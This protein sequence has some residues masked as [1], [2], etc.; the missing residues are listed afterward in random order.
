MNNINKIKN[1]K[2]LVVGF[3]RSGYASAKI[4]KK[5]GANVTLTAI[6]DLNGNSQAEE[7]I[8]L[9]V[10]I[11]SGS[12]PISLL[13]NIDFIVKNPGIKYSGF[14]KEALD[15]NIPV[16]TEIEFTSTL[17]NRDIVAITGTNGKTTTTQ[18][19]YDILK[20]DNKKV[21]LA[22]NIGY[23]SIEVAYNSK[24]GAILVT[25]VSS[26]QLEGTD[27]FKPSIAIITNMT[28]S[29]LD[30][31]DNIENYHNAK[32]KIFK[33]QTKGDYLILNSKD[34][35]KFDIDKINSNILFYSLEKNLNF[36]IY[37]DNNNV[38][39]KGIELFNVDKLLLPGSHNIENA[40]N[41]AVASYLKG[42]SLESIRKIL[43]T[44]TGVKHRLQYL[45]DIKGVKYY[46][47]SKST[48]SIS[49]IKAISGFE[50]NV[51]LICGGK[52]RN[53][54]FKDIIPHLSSVKTIIATGETKE[55]FYNLGVECNIESYKCDRIE[56]G[57]LLASK[58]AVED[59]IVLLSPGCASWGQ[60]KNFEE[61]GDIF[62][63]IFNEFKS[64]NI[65]E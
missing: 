1:K 58:L 52:D 47:D 15:R 11:V 24:E 13:E 39:Y 43:Y 21:H 7:L 36:D 48:N 23:P 34:I 31:H 4:F 60:Y 25:E 5:L 49:L 32:K 65:N 46:N 29:H 51:I 50:K 20:E 38:I 2:V 33:N 6:E 37:V 35:N 61:R 17:F 3:A 44:F 55:L 18:M 8:D 26:F 54:D 12:H 62:I 53:L 30:Y 40:I 16:Y 59:D 10:K 22:G 45:G 27:K 57:T 64:E 14:I 19:I 42:A 41:A 56:D 28:E 9:G 63:K